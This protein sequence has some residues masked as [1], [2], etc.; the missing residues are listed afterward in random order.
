MPRYDYRCDRCN[1]VHEEEHSIH[2]PARAYIICHC[3][4]APQPATRLVT[5]APGVALKGYGFYRKDTLTEA[6]KYDYDHHGES[7]TR[8]EE[9]QMG[10]RIQDPQSTVPGSRLH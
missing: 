2:D 1:A 5:S 9:L 10:R 3:S 8:S 6:E 4:P 7:G